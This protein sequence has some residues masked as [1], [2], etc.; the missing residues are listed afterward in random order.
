MKSNRVKLSSREQTSRQRGGGGDG[1]RRTNLG[2]QTPRPEIQS[3]SQTHTGNNDDI[4]SSAD[5]SNSH[6][7]QAKSCIA[8]SERARARHDHECV[9]TQ[10]FQQQATHDM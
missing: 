6:K 3:L 9:D 5:Y 8:M 7:A 10:A 4:I 2:F 1:G